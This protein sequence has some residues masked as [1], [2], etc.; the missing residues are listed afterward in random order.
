MESVVVEH[1]P[2]IWSQFYTDDGLFCY[3]RN[4]PMYKE[5]NALDSFLVQHC[6]ELPVFE[7]L[8][9]R[10]DRIDQ[11]GANYV[12]EYASHIAVWRSGVYS[13][14]ALGK[15]LRIWRRE[16]DGGLKIYRHIGMYD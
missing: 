6:R 5:K 14:V 16:K 10:T 1:D 3:S 11:P 13:G 8:D 7:K 12:I 15:D 4:H 9:I 2:L